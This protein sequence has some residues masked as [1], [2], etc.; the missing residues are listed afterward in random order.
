M[1][2]YGFFYNTCVYET[3][4]CLV[5]LHENITTAIAAMNSHKKAYEDEYGKPYD[6]QTWKVVEVDVLE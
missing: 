3:S 1:T 5:S 2:L 4:D 6:W